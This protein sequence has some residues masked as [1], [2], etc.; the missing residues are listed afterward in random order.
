MNPLVE[1]RAWLHGF[2]GAW[3]TLI[4]MGAHAHELMV[5]ATV[6]IA[7]LLI[8]KVRRSP[9]A[10]NAGPKGQD[11]PASSTSRCT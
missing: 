1:I 6:W 4:L 8:I 11:D 10:P 7:G 2:P 3:D 5:G 9:S